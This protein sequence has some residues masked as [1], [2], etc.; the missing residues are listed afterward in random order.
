MTKTP[1]FLQTVGQ[2]YKDFIVTESLPIPEL[3]CTLLELVHEPTGAAVIHLDSDDPENLFCL[4]FRTLPSSSNGAA[5]ILEHTVLCG[6]KKFP[7]KDPFFAMSRRSLNTFMNAMT[8]SDFTCYPAATQVEKDFYN[9]LDVYIDA[10]FHPEIKELS[11]LQEG[12][13]LEF[14]EPEDPKTPLQ[15]KGIVYNEMKGSL[16]SADSRL[17]HAMLGLLCPD[18][19]YAHNSGGDP[20][21]IPNLT[22]EQLVAFHKKFYH[23]SRCLFFFYGNFPLKKHLD[24]LEEKA[25]KNVAKLDSL[26]PIPKQKRYATPIERTLRY[27]IAQGEDLSKK[28]IIAFGWLTT[29]VINQEEV[30][31]LS[32]LD[33]VW[34]DTDASPLKRALLNSGLSLQANGFM[35]VEMSEVPYVIV[36]KGCDAKD[37]K[38]LE[39]HLRASLEK[40]AEEGIPQ[41]IADAAIHQL[42][43]ART[44]ISSDQN[45]YGLTLFMRSALA[46]QHG[47]QLQDGLKIH[48][49]FTKLIE[50]VKD[51]Q[52]LS[53]LIR[54]YF[55]DNPHQVTLLM[56]PDPGLGAEEIAEEAKALEKIQ[57]RLTEK[58]IA[59]IISQAKQLATYQVETENQNLDCLPKVDFSDVPVLARMY[60]LKQEKV[61]N[62]TCFHH[63]CFTNH[64]LYADL[65]FD[66]PAVSE[67]ELLYVPLMMSLLA[68]VGCGGRDYLANLEYIQ[69]HTGG[70]QGGAAVHVQ[71]VDPNAMKPS[72]A[73]RGKALKRNAKPFFALMREMATSVRFDEKERIKEL[74]LKQNTALQNR[75]TRNAHRYAIQ[76]SLSGFS[77]PSLIN[78]RWGG[79]PYF[80]MIQGFAERIDE[81]LPTIIEKLESLKQKLFSL[82]DP[83]L[84]L[85]CTKEMYEELRAQN[86]YG[87]TTLNSHTTFAPWQGNYVVTPVVSQARAIASP[88]AFTSLA[89]KSISYSHPYASALSLSTFLF[90]NKVLH[91]QIREKGGAYGCGATY[92][93]INALVYFHSFRDPNLVKTVKTFHQ[94]IDKVA[95]GKFEERDLEEAKMGMMQQLDT[96]IAPGSRAITAYCWMREGRTAQMRQAY[97]DS[98]LSRTSKEVAKAVE[99]ELLPKKEE[100][101][102]VCFAGSDLLEKEN[103]VLSKKQKALPIFPI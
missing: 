80:K 77:V 31:A 51:P 38:K 36:C 19:P 37:L 72:L 69:A 8:G 90:E 5:H 22:Y 43:F 16:S 100:G 63:A 70:V 87:L 13:R 59:K 21:E 12:H 32:V 1:P 89:F 6:S 75:L 71:A 81:L 58:E 82:H 42:E 98:L 7:V 61:G 27:P 26:P 15:F 60:A 57:A 66:L 2:R 103:E 49:L 47:C 96:P 41:H 78:D 68:E 76:L 99:M 52:Y 92:A 101:V 34:M 24:Y 33:S 56:T 97:R 20:K 55:L 50:K 62:L 10:V 14:T 46:K 91:P 102:L 95:A 44:E 74:I 40:I 30:L 48:S 17:W 4:S 54:K 23:P 64:I 39:Y 35:D 28:A 25:L 18:L 65:I 45:P 79:L 29:P 67:E 11:F 94:A 85:S 88:V 3:N 83:H 73:I 93:P 84:V 86:F 9:L 53:G